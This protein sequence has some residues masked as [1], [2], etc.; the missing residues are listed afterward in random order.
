MA[1]ASTLPFSKIRLL[2]ENPATPNTFVKICGVNQRTLN[3]TKS[4]GEQPVPDCADDDLPSAIVRALESDDWNISFNGVLTAEGVETSEAFY[5]ASTSWRIKW[6]E[7]FPAP[8]GLKTFSG[9]AHMQ[10][11]SHDVSRGTHGTITATLIADGKLTR[12]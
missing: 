3:R 6:E 5:S 8:V 1:L 9:R 10:D 12:A 11:M 2:V 7:E 4:F